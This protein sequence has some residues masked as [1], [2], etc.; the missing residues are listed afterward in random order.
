MPEK[1]NVTEISVRPYQEI[2]REAVRKIFCDTAFMGQPMELF[3]DDRQIMGDLLT[4]YY[5][6]YE[7]ESLFV[8]EC[9][10]RI[11][12]C[13]TGCTDSAR[14]KRIWSR[15]LFFRIFFRLLNKGLIFKRK[16]SRLLFYLARSFFKGEFNRPG[17][18]REYP[19]HFHI[20]I[21]NNYRRLQAGTKLLA[22]FFEYLRKKN[23]H[24]VYAATFSEQGRRFFQESGFI[25]L[26]ERKN[27]Q[28][29][30]LLNR[31]V[32]TSLFA[33]LLD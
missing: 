14:K 7:P 24:G 2:D 16:T 12:G 30:Y 13:L 31:D 3:F 29:H 23:I 6:D 20:N 4:L 15:K 22:A 10:G 33:I 19:A 9:A 8:A 25:L 18:P 1:N 32:K 28:W 27:S 11:V 26:W 17:I 5:T 21:H